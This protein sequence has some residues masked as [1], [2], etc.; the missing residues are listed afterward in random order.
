[1]SPVEVLRAARV[2]VASGFTVTA[3]LE[4]SGDPA[5]VILAETF[6]ARQL[7][8]PCVHSWLLKL[9][10]RLGD[11]AD[12]QLV[13]RNLSELG[14]SCVDVADRSQGEVVKCFTLAIQRAQKDG[15]R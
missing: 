7:G 2:L 6:L 12:R 15:Y 14:V 13:E 5:S 3:A 4:N 9:R 8:A 10:D 11:G 1:V